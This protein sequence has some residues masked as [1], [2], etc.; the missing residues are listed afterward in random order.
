MAGLEIKSAASPD[1][2]RKFA[3]KGNAKVMNVSGHPVLVG[4]YEPGWR[5]SEHVKPLVGTGSCQAPHLMY[6]LSGRMKIIMDDG[7]AGEVGPGDI[8][9]VAPGHDAWVIGNETCTAVDFGGYAQYA[10]G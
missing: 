10:K 2:T 3:A 8:A 5:W 1:E 4:T 6:V 9:A 7:T